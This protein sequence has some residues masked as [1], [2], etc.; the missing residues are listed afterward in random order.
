MVDGEDDAS[1]N[2]NEDDAS[3]VV[4]ATINNTNGTV[5]TSCGKQHTV[6]YPGVINR[7]LA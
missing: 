1:N 7:L 6:L 5:C 3:R 4:N 2:N